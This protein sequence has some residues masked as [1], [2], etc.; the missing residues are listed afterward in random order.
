MQSVLTAL[1]PN[2]TNTNTSQLFTV[3]QDAIT[4]VLRSSNTFQITTPQLS[5]SAQK[6][7]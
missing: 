1:I 4:A 5:I 2:N 6:V 7:E 3:L